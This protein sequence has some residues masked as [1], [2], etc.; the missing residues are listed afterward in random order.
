MCSSIG[1]T[2]MKYTIAMCNFE[3]G[4]VLRDSLESVLEQV[5]ETQFEVLVVDGG[6]EDNSKQVIS[7][8]QEEYDN[9]RGKFLPK[10]AGRHLGRDRQISIEEAN[11]EYVLFDIDC[12]DIYH[13]GV[14]DFVKIYHKLEDARNK[15]FILKGEAINMA[16]K[17]LLREIPFRNIKIAEDK[18]LYRR[19]LKEDKII[20]LQHKRFWE[21][22]K[23]HE[24]DRKALLKRMYH[25]QISHFRVSITLT[26]FI[27]WVFFDCLNYTNYTIKR[28]VAELA[29]LPLTFTKAILSSRFQTP[30]PYNR[31]GKQYSER[32]QKRKST[33]ELENEY[34]LSIDKSELTDSGLEAFYGDVSYEQVP[35]NRREPVRST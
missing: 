20:Y 28:R 6:S 29:L 22:T 8:L 16:P 7:D 13:R 9:L 25:E 12:D 24:K 5:P 4:D 26:S 33:E 30:E 17:S 11:G 27:Y 31:M 14:C 32:F 1:N 19:A 23:S 34:D 3:M 10:D 15:E 21:E 2:S 35:E 18:D